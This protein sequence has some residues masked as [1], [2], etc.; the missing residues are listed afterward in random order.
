[1]TVIEDINEGRDAENVCDG[2][3]QGGTNEISGNSCILRPPESSINS[4]RL[5]SL[6]WPVWVKKR[7][8]AIL[9]ARD[10]L[11]ARQAEELIARAPT[12]PPL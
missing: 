5:S 8:A 12:I 6:R 11:L 9:L 1:M 4:A 7:M 10:T 3:S 2:T